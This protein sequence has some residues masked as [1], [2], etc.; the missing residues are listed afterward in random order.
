[1]ILYILILII[2]AVLLAWMLQLKSKKD[3]IHTVFIKTGVSVCFML[4]AVVCTSLSAAKGNAAEPFHYY[5]IPG[6]LFGLLGDIWLGLKSY[7]SDKKDSFT[8]AGFIS[9]LIGH[10]FYI[11]GM[12]ICFGNSRALYIVIP[13]AAGVIIGLVMGFG[14]KLMKVRF[15]SYRPIVIIYGGALT[16]MTLLAGSLALMHGWSV[17][18]LDMMFAGGILFLTS[19]LILCQMYFGKAREESVGFTTANLITYY[20]AMFV[21][22]SSLA[23]A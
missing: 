8:Y 6:L 7:L 10:L 1:M 20:A 9:F 3:S 13:I 23:F 12:I 21:I 4:A 14:E 16:S 15:G 5:V 18:T 19:D 11:A 2:T 22:A 17:V